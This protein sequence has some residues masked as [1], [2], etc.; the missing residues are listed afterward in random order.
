MSPP[1]RLRAALENTIRAAAIVPPC[2]S[3]DRPTTPYARHAPL[4]PKIKLL[5]GLANAAPRAGVAF[6]TIPA[7]PLF[8][9]RCSSR[10]AP[11]THDDYSDTATADPK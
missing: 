5:V 4:V 6:N 7:L 11:T 8:V 10:S 9:P 3:E 1:A 2:S